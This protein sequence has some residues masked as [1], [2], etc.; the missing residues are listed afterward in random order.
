MISST[1]SSSTFSLSDD[2]AREIAESVEA[3]SM[4]HLAPLSRCPR[5]Y[6]VDKQ[7]RELLQTGRWFFLPS[8]S[9]GQ[10]RRCLSE[11]L[12]PSESPSIC[13]YR[14][15]GHPGRLY[16]PASIVLPVAP[17]RKQAQL[18]DQEGDGQHG[19]AK[20]L[21]RLGDMERWVLRTASE[22]R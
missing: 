3:A 21:R 20:L 13:G 14:V 1:S 17:P 10:T 11:D 9:Q 19:G 2:D 8:F 7:T 22:A 5:C 16:S 4:T 18:V 6:C 15:A 12:V